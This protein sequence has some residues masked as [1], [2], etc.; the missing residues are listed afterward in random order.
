MQ[1][2]KHFDE[3]ATDGGAFDTTIRLSTKEKTYI[4]MAL[5][6]YIKELSNYAEH[7]AEAITDIKQ[8]IKAL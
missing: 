6:H 3:P 1:V 8:M 5:E 2:K 7:H 4:H